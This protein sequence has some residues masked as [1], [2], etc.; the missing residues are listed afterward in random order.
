LPFE[1]VLGVKESVNAQ[2]AALASGDYVGGVQADRLA[3]AQV[4]HGE[5]DFAVGE[6][7]GAVIEFNAAAGHLEALVEA[8]LSGTLTAVLG[9]YVANVD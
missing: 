5:Y 3:G 8:T 9:A 6:V 7:G 4:G 1:S 2:V